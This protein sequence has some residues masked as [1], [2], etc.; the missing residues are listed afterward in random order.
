[1]I[2][3]I[4]AYYTDL[5]SYKE[6]IKS[7]VLK[8]FKGRFKYTALGYFW[9][10]LNP[11]VLI[12]IYM[13]VFSLIFGRDI[14][15]YWAYLSTGMFAYSFF[16]SCVGGGSNIIVGSAKL[17]TKMAFKREILV[18]SRLISN[19]ITFACDKSFA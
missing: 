6:F 7:I 9:H 10:I 17:I 2:T 3:S 12:L 11:L 19:A 5:C 8:E 1:M 16:S 14:P 18:I 4:Y 15:H 13:A